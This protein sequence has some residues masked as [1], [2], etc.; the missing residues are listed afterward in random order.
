MLLAHFFVYCVSRHFVDDGGI[1]VSMVG[2]K[3]VDPGSIPGH[4]KFLC[5]R[6]VKAPRF[7]EAKV[8][9]CHTFD[10]EDKK[11]WNA[12]RFCVSS[13]AQGPC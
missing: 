11:M 1:L 12:S 13:F 10:F 3:A 8:L 4:R 9:M 7:V 6:V 2:F 5:G